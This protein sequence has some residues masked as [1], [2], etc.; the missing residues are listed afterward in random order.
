[1]AG[2]PSRW[3]KEGALRLVGGLHSRRQARI[4]VVRYDTRA[5]QLCPFTEDVARLTVCIKRVGTWGGSRLDLGVTLGWRM[6]IHERAAHEAAQEAM[7]VFS[8]SPPPR[9]AALPAPPASLSEVDIMTQVI[10]LRPACDPAYTRRL[11]SAPLLFHQ[12]AEPRQVVGAFDR[13]LRLLFARPRMLFV[14]LAVVAR[15]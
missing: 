6:L 4:G 3:M 15:E 13:V 8:G 7:V 11:A 1:M 2:A 14:P 10:C 12:V 9:Q 5:S